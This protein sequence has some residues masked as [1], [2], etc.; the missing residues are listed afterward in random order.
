MS[1]QNVG[2]EKVVFGDGPIAGGLKARSTI[3]ASTYLLYACG[4][5]SSNR[6][7]PGH[8]TIEATTR[9]L[10]PT[11]SRLILGPLRFVN[12]DC[13][14]NS[15]VSLWSLASAWGTVAH[16]LHLV[17][18]HPKLECVHHHNASPDRGR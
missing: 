12:H 14:A 15:Q 6:H 18:S 9:Q 11:G 3:R 16:S 4:S 1:S 8:A 7:K 13:N 2:L 5:L 10:G 17:I